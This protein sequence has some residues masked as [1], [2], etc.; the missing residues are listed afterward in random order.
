MY[1]DHELIRRP[2]EQQ[3]SVTSGIHGRVGCSMRR[4]PRMAG[5]LLTCNSAGSELSSSFVRLA[6]SV[7]V[8][9]HTPGQDRWAWSVNVEGSDSH[10][11]YRVL[12]LNR[13]LNEFLAEVEYLLESFFNTTLAKHLLKSMHTILHI[14]TIFKE[15]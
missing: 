13:I 15:N 3:K 14:A 8:L 12:C 7:R 10:L 6:P 1:L 5:L 2:L 11:V 4:G 9:M